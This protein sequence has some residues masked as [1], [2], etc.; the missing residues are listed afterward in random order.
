MEPIKTIE[1]GSQDCI[2][3]HCTK[4]K[5]YHSSTFYDFI[6]HSES[7]SVQKPLPMV[8]SNYLLRNWK[9]ERRGELVDCKSTQGGP[10]VAFSKRHARID[11]VTVAFNSSNSGQM[12]CAETGI[13]TIIRSLTQ[14]DSQEVFF[15]NQLFID[16]FNIKRKRQYK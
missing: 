10:V 16:F 9:S 1:T 8:F 3:F 5:T 11:R 7:S 13:C 15:L 14:Y 6:L 2:F 4:G 12:A